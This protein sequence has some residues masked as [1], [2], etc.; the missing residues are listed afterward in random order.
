MSSFAHFWQLAVDFIWGLPLVFLVAAA[1]LYF[2]YLSRLLPFLR[3]RHTWD[4]LRGR[5]SNPNDPGEIPHF[6]ALS[7]ALSGTIG[8]GNIAGVALAISV[9]RPAGHVYQV[10]HLHARLHVPAGG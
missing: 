8:M 4:L 10:L 5:Y 9:G 3:L 7:S 1:A 2:A 6:Q